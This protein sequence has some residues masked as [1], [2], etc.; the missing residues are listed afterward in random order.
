M[1]RKSQM[2]IAGTIQAQP[3]S[4]LPRNAPFC[5]FRCVPTFR[6]SYKKEIATMRK[7]TIVMLI[8]G[9]ISAGAF[10]QGTGQPSGAVQGQVFITDADGG[11]SVV[12]ATKIMLDGPT[13]LEALSDNEGKFALSAVPAGSYTIAANTP[14]MTATQGVVVI[15]GSVSQAQLEM[16]LEAVTESTTVTATTDSVNTKTELS[17]T[18]TI[19]ESAVHNMPNVDEHFQSLLPL[20]ALIVGHGVTSFYFVLLRWSLT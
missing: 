4:P 9:L 6:A 7:V 12:A 15:A 2:E 16:K 18:N 10:A 13:H 1:A 14:G 17:G 19:A 3:V 20:E 8:L 5:S 11:R